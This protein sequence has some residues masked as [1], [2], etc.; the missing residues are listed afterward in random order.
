MVGTT[1][2]KNKLSQLHDKRFYFP[3]G[4]VSLPFHYPNLAKIYEF[5]QKKVQRIEKY[6]W[7]EKEHLFRL[8][9]EALKDHPRLYLYHQILKSVPKI[10]N[11]SQKDDFTRQDK[12]LFKKS[13][14]DIIFEGRWI[15][16]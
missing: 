12:S 14:K 1:V 9:K 2:V 3:H 8:E 5:K 16:K 4:I 7:N 6:F 10:F 15:I 13:T 11:I